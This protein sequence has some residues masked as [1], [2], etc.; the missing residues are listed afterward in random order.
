[1]R[2]F[3]DESGDLGTGGGGTRWFTYAA[4]CIRDSDG[5]RMRADFADLLVKT[6][7]RR[8]VHFADWL[9]EERVMALNHWRGKPWVGIA[10]SSDTTKIPSGRTALNDPLH[11][12]RY[13]LRYVLERVSQYAASCG[14]SCRVTIETGPIKPDGLEEYLAALRFKDSQPGAPPSLM[15]WEFL[16]GIDFARKEEEHLLGMSDALSHSLQRV[17]EPHKRSGT[18]ETAY[19]YKVATN[20]WRG[21]YEYDQRVIP[22]GWVFMPTPLTAEFLQEY[23]MIKDLEKF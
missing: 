7:G 8:M 17:L 3:I 15:R 20:L 1:L 6:K 12:G 5:H 16:S 22:N 4:V 10:A 19:M 18:T 13:V 2:A 23:W 9:H 14:E 21:T 11:H